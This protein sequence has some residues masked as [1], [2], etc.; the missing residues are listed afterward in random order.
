MYFMTNSALASDDLTPE[1]QFTEQIDYYSNL[2]YQAMLQ[3]VNLTP[4]PGLVDRVSNGAHRDMTL[5]HFYQ[6]AEAISPYFKAFIQAG[7]T[8]Y[9]QPETEILA[10]IRPIGIACEQAMFTATHQINTHKGSI[11]SL[12]LLCVA[13]GRTLANQQPLSAN[14]LC[15]QVARFC[16]G[17]TE[18]ELQRQNTQL[19]AGQRLF[20]QHGL[21]G[22]RGEA[23]SG[24]QTVLTVSLPV[25]LE[26]CQQ[27]IPQ[28]LALHQALLNLLAHNDDTN[29]VSRG[30]LEGLSWLKNHAQ[31]LINSGGIFNTQSIQL[32]EEFDQLCIEKNLSPGGS[33]DLLILTWFLAQLD[34][35]S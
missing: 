21:T 13:I 30:G 17:M 35:S 10:L 9:Q 18:R 11:F 12:G 19:T 29:V 31:Q 2:A 5:Q 20:I 27:N 14:S 34:S 7:I 28:E 24:F 15:K 6:S 22:A 32:I 4:K 3:E 23:E 33:A 1:K 16:Q 26:L 8:H 25:Y